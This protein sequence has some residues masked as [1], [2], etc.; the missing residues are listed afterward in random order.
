M[1]DKIV[2]KGGYLSKL[3]FYEFGRIGGTCA[4]LAKNV[5]NMRWKSHVLM[6]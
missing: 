6:I 4:L 2:R 1:A 3:P 5:Y